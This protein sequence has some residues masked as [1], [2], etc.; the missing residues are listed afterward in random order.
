MI[1]SIIIFRLL[2]K[3]KILELFGT[4]LKQ[5][6]SNKYNKIIITTYKGDVDV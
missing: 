2:I 5:Q 1:L 3:L 4:F 6:K